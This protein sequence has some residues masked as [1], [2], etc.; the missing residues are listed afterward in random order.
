MHVGG[1][2]VSRCIFEPLLKEPPVL[3]IC[4]N[5]S[6]YCDFVLTANELLENYKI[7]FRLKRSC[8]SS[9][10]APIPP[11]HSA[12]CL[13]LSCRVDEGRGGGSEKY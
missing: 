11:P 10:P 9:L 3:N 6:V 13:Q 5:K 7:S 8:G 1:K 2:F 12:T 4:R